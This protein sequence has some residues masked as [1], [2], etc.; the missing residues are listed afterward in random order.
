[1]DMKEQAIIDRIKELEAQVEQLKDK[2]RSL[3][4]NQAKL[5]FERRALM[6]EPSLIPQIFN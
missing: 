2:N 3:E 1:M 4:V 5:L 6:T